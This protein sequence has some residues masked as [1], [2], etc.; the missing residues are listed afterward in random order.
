MTVREAELMLEEK[1]TKYYNKP[2][3]QL[4]VVNRRVVVFPGGG[5]DAKTRAFGEQQHHTA[6][7]V[8]TGRWIEQTRRCPQGQGVP[9]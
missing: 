6:G 8:G 5:G 1:Y 4:L 3:V 9:V 7:G 2:Y